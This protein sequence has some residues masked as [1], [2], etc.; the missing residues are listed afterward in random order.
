ML[1]PPPIGRQVDAAC[2][3]EGEQECF[4]WKLLASQHLASVAAAEPYP[5][6]MGAGQVPACM[7]CPLIEVSEGRFPEPDMKQA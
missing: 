3:G 6:Q 5:F 2:F 4:P 1:A 7:C